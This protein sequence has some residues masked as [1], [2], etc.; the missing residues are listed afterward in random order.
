MLS[1]DIAKGPAAATARAPPDGSAP[2]A[3]AEGVSNPS[4]ISHDPKR[5]PAILPEG[6]R[7]LCGQR[8]SCRKRLKRKRAG[9]SAR[10]NWRPIARK[11]EGPDFSEPDPTQ[12]AALMDCPSTHLRPYPS[13]SRSASPCPRPAS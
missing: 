6:L 7:D 13:S 11:Q 9:N 5:P 3:S 1:M 4:I 2:Q 12:G 8:L 10:T